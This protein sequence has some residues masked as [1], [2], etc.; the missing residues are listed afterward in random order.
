MNLTYTILQ[1]YW[2][3]IISLLC[4]L[5]TLMMFVQGGQS[6]LYTIGRT[7]KQRD[8]ILESLGSKWELTFTTLVTFGGAFFASFPLFYCTSFGGAFY[9]WMAILFV[10]VLQ[11]AGYG[12]SRRQNNLLGDRTYEIFL[13]INGFFGPFLLGT[14]IGTFFTG[15]HFT[16]DLNN[17]TDMHGNNA[18]SQWDNRWYG[19]EALTDYRN[20]ALGLAVLLLTRILALQYFLNDIDDPQIKSRCAAR[21]GY[22]AAPFLIMFLTFFISILLS[23]GY[24]VAPATGIVS[25][26]KYKYLHNLLQMPYI[27]VPMLLGTAAILAGIYT[28]WRRQAA[29]AVWWSGSGTVVTVLCL[30]LTAGWNDTCYYPSLSSMQSSLNIYNSSSSLYTL[31]AMSIVSVMIP[32]VV[33]YIWA[34]WK[35]IA[36]R[37]IAKST[38]VAHS[39][40]TGHLR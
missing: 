33:W 5:L 39:D 12:L 2:W 27:S 10:F 35:S 26:E 7:P 28:G 30:M 16:V 1:H 4:A 19:L 9:V 22:A 20:T 34:A 31:S 24:A 3:L 23:D 18:I 14:A 17:L 36:G 40:E 32:F 21:I 29:S 8:A 25:P 13:V 38:T 37:N 15:G 11:A 6:L